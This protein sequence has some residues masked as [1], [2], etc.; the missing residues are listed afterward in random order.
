[1]KYIPILF[2]VVMLF[3]ASDLYCAENN[4]N[5][6]N[7]IADDETEDIEAL[8][9]DGK[10]KIDYEK[11]DPFAGY[12]KNLLSLNMFLFRNTLLPMIFIIDSWTPKFAK[13]GYTNFVNNLIEPRNWLVYA[14]NG[15]R[16]K[17]RRALKRFFIN[18]TFG[19]LGLI[20]VTE[21]KWGDKSKRMSVDCIFRKNNKA[22]R[23]LVSPITNQYFE[24]TMVSDMFD[25]AL[26]PVFYFKL[27]FNYLMYTVDK[28]IILG[29]DKN[30]L[31]RNRKYNDAIY[32]T[33][34]DNEIYMLSKADL[35]E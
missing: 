22:G 4:D 33:L 2:F 25:W 26:N 9:N 31:Y 13:L 19:V 8:L 10:E 16:K 17:A 24:R 14:I 35:C 32:K 7:E 27:P 23:Y 29:K 28:L 15:D 11:I 20:N 6:H 3:D 18:S 21:R 12:N 34:L 30:L 5:I 1:M